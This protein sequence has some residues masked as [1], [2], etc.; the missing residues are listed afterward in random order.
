MHFFS[1][2]HSPHMLHLLLTLCR[3]DDVPRGD[4]IWAVAV[5]Q[6]DFLLLSKI[7]LL[8]QET[9]ISFYKLI[10]EASG[11]RRHDG[12][13]HALIAIQVHSLIL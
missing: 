1:I 7:W 6:T 2:L 3:A 5:P 10:S 8:P 4:S 9:N 11:S 13:G 12:C